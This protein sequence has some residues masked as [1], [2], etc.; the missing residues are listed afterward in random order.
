MSRIKDGTPF[1]SGLLKARSS[2][3]HRAMQQCA[4]Q[5]CVEQT[6]ESSDLGP[7][8]EGS[9]TGPETMARPVP[10]VYHLDMEGN[11]AI[12]LERDHQ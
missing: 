2:Q 9:G 5:V 11:D 12:P 3:H 10:L 1:Q 4:G 8:V 7:S 6:L